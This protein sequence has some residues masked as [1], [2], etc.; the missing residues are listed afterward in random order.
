MH[1]LLK[2]ASGAHAA[3]DASRGVDPGSSALRLRGVSKTFPGV[4]A[5]RAIDLDVAPGSVHALLGHNG[6]GKST[7]VKTLAGIH[8]PDPGADAWIGGK[9]LHLGDLEDAER[10][11]LRFVHQDLGIVPELGAADNIGLALGYRRRRI[12]GIDW[13]AQGEVARELLAEFGFAIDPWRPL[14]EASPPERAAVAIVRAVAGSRRGHGVVVLD[15]PTAAL[16]AHEVDQLFSMIRRISATGTAVLLVSHR[17]DEVLSIAD[18]ATVMRAGE[19]VWSGALTQTTIGRLV[20]LIA[21]AGEQAGRPETD[22]PEH[23]RARVSAGVVLDA[24]DV[25]GRHL[26]GVSLSLHAGEVVGVAGLLGSGR[27]ELPYVLAGGTT[28]GVSGAFTIDGVT[29]RALPIAKARA[30]GLAL[31][32]ADRAGEGIFGDFT[33]RENVTLPGLPALSRR[34]VFGP[35]AERSFGRRWLEAVRA[36]PRSDER[37]ITTL[38]GG[39][40]QKAVLARWLSVQPRL[41]VLAEPTAGVDIG[42]R[43]AIY[44]ELRRRAGDGLAVLMASSDVEDLLAACDRVIVLRDGVVVAELAGREIN[45]PAIVGAMEGAHREHD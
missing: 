28:L 24:R 15:E 18:H 39:N 1:A 6:C 45:K 41:L 10:K 16:P 37:P 7:L 25:V 40:Q 2:T 42:A 22:R 32:P 44:D 13:R 14:A 27:E 4:R 36:D 8:S 21:D 33:A 5:L 31:V 9:K 23:Q 35:R 43:G 34:G 30:L 38:S 29:H 3:P 20:D 12:P 17:L 11:G 26:R 19:V